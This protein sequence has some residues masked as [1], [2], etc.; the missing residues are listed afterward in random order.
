MRIRVPTQRK[1]GMK[2]R[3]FVVMVLAGGPQQTAF[4]AGEL[5]R[6]RDGNAAFG[7]NEG[8]WGDGFRGRI[9]DNL[10]VSLT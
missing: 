1:W 4:G 3:S 6:I 7:V 8:K 2:N 5:A 10:P 9:D